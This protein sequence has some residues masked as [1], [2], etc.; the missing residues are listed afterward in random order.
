MFQRR[1][2]IP[3]ISS[4]LIITAIFC[5]TTTTSRADTIDQIQKQIEKRNQDIANLEKEIKSYQNQ[6]DD[7]GQ[8]A[9]S[10][11][12]AIKSLDLTRKKFEADIK[13]TENKIENKNYEI[14]NLNSQIHSKE[15][16]ISDDKRIIDNVFKEIYKT[17]NNSLIEKVLSNNSIAET[18]SSMEKLN[19]LQGRLYDRINTLNNIKLDLEANKKASEKAKNDLI[20]L[21]NE[22]NNQRDL[23]KSATNEKNQLLNETKQSEAEY[24]RILANK[25]E[26]KQSIEKEI[27]DF[28]SQLKIMIDTS[29]LPKTGSGVLSWPLDAVTITQYFGNTDFA[30]ANAQVYNG[31]GHNGIDLRASVGTPV[32][33]ALLGTVVGVGNTGTVRTCYSYG[34]WVLIQHPNGLSTLYAHL[35]LQSVSEGQSVSTGQIIG[36]SGNTGYTTGSHLHFGVY[37]SQGIEVVK[38]TNSRN[39]RGVRLPVADFK[40]YLNPLSYL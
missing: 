40:A 5:F 21:K 2:I 33:S 3:A 18:L 15:D 22:L 7:L 31:K 17:D 20:T 12:S 38:L 10:L 37:A 34:K 28:E 4:L 1:N 26:L 30:T 8:Q 19:S 13:I 9:N 29:K 16:D 25:Q 6:I 36:Y 14:S 39:C 32:K 23:V 11:K 27:L 24:Q 35:S